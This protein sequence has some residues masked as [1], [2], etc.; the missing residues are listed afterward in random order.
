M[1]LK[2]QYDKKGYVILDKPF[3]EITDQE[4]IRQAK[5][6]CI[7]KGM[8]P[9][10]VPTHTHRLNDEALAV[11]RAKYSE[12][13]EVI[14]AFVNKFLSSGSGN[15]VLI[16][17]TDNEGFI[18]DFA[19]DPTI[20]ET[21]RYL[22]IVEGSGYCAEDGPSSIDLC[23]NYK[24][25][26]TLIGED[27][28]HQILHGMACYSAPFHGESGKEIIGTIS[29]MTNKEFVHPH[30]HALLCTM[31]DSLEREMVTRKQNTQ[32]QTLNQVLLGTNHYGVI[33]TDAQG[34]ILEMNEHCLS[35]LCPDRSDRDRS[36]Y[37][38]RSV[39]GIKPI[40]EYYERVI[41]RQEVCIGEELSLEISGNVNHYIL[42]VQPAYDRKGQIMRVVGSLRDI[43]EMKRTEEVLRNTEKL[44]F[45]GQ[46]AVSIAHEV[47][48]PLTTVKGMLQLANKDARLRHYDLIMSELE[49]ANLM[50]GE[51]MILGKPQ[52]AVLKQEDC[53]EIL[54]EVLHL[55]AIQAELSGIEMTQCFVQNAVILC[56]RNQIKQVFLNILKNA[57]EALPYGGNIH[58]RLDVQEGYQRVIFTDNGSGMTEEVLQRI[59]EPFHTTKPDGNGLGIM[60]VHRIMESH[61]GRI[62]I[63]SEEE[64]GTSVEIGLPLP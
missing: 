15:P 54:E 29:L 52:A 40:G 6:Q 10:L 53:G 30:L 63:R 27:H 18:L 3:G 21:A 20:I 42:D 14:Q 11:R 51:F 44:V 7:D 60:I 37:V 50:V 9:E 41:Q 34:Q 12:Y 8:N 62:V 36:N 49:R 33:I 2:W 26:F 35:L 31:A 45:A 64:R 56:D 25:P 4:I 47:R 38:S 61:H 59:G 5:Q 13:I 48:N 28:F 39:F 17:I 24:R 55:F 23:L 32:L 57:M 58:I 16:T 1:T 19:G 22:G 46:V 43:T